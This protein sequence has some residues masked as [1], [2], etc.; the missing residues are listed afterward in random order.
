MSLKI[1][2]NTDEVGNLCSHSRDARDG[3]MDDSDQQR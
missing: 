2:A 3:E 1:F